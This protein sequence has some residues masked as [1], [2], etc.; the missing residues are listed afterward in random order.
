MKKLLIIL[1]LI[2]SLIV[3][4]DEP[5]Y[6]NSFNSSNNVFEFK[7]S[8]VRTDS[9]LIGNEY[10]K[11]TK[12][13]KWSLYNSKDKTKIYDIEIIASDKT[14][15]ISNDGQY[16]VVINDW[17][18]ETPDNDL[19][20]VIIFNNGLLVKSIKY[21]DILDCGYNI[22]SSASHFSWIFNEPKVLF[23]E[24]QISLV[25]YEL[26]EIVISITDG[27]MVKSRNK[28]VDENSILTYGKIIEKKGVNYKLEICHKAFGSATN[29]VEFKSK[30]KFDKGWYYTILVNNKNEIDIQ[31]ERRNLNDV[32]LNTC[33]PEPQNFKE[34][35]IDFG[36][37]NCR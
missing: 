29:I 10:Y 24:N 7:I 19:E 25:T 22:S 31:Y 8:Q 17:P 13:V 6:R 34:D 23:K 30:K 36:K 1:F 2:T 35:Y 32:S 28:F 37:I 15:Y 3:N 11:S 20:M 21:G 5:R 12:E 16:I 26:N 18:A 9:V 4:A 27:K 14:A 33:L